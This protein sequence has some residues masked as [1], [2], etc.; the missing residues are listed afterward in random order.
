MVYILI[1]KILEGHALEDVGN[2]YGHLVH[3]AAI[4]YILQPLGIFHGHL[5]YFSP[6]LV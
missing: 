1:P 6:V 4:W 2:F 5:V 3:F